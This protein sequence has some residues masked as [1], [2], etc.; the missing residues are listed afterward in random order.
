[1]L[2]L[3]SN[4]LGD[5]FQVLTGRAQIKEEQIAQL[6]QQVYESM[7]E[8]DVP[9]E[10]ARD[11]VAEV[12]AELA[13]L[14]KNKIKDLASTVMDVFNRRLTALL[15]QDATFNAASLPL[16]AVILVMGVQGSGKT[17]T[18]AK[19]GAHI[20]EA[21]KGKRKIL[22]ASVDFYRPAAIDQMEVMAKKAGVD[23]YRAKSTDPVAAAK[24]IKERFERHRYDILL[25]DT[26]GR[27]HVDTVLLDE[28]KEIDKLVRPTFRLLVIDAMVGQQSL[29]IA[30]TFDAAVPF[31]GACLAKMDSDTR[32]G[33]AV[34][35][36]YAL[37]KPIFFVGVGER[38]TDFELWR[39]ERVVRQLIGM[40]D[41]ETLFDRAAR[42]A[43][44]TTQQVA[45]KKNDRFTLEDFAEQLTVMRNLGSVGSIMRLMPHQFKGAMAGV[46]MDAADK[47]LKMVRAMI[48]SMTLKE[49]RLEVVLTS[50]RIK[51]IASGSGVAIEKVT[52]LLNRFKET[53]EYVMLLKKSGPF[54]QLFK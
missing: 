47:D 43:P 12:K 40:G 20:L 36:R 51:R 25:L 49:R 29:A 9:Y 28:L 22:A 30:R 39:P 5:A 38:V 53:S 50:S 15:G 2:D 19:L 10:V 54:K 52:S 21:T 24:E 14:H 7:I 6:T 16:P 26:A 17:T 31:N 33:V 4:K 37:K 48:D 13:T 1:M 8:A 45:Q 18:I 41:L 32:G 42:Y 35:F 34:S 3:L 44:Q 23:V 27:T 11:F 46:D